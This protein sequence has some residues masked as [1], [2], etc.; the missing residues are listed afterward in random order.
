MN[1]LKFHEPHKPI[2]FT[3]SISAKYLVVNPIMHTRMKHIKINFYFIRDL[4]VNNKLD[5]RFKPSCKQVADVF[6]KLLSETK[7]LPLNFKLMVLPPL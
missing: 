6:T 3:N 7:F 5:V 4:V 2:F 1:W